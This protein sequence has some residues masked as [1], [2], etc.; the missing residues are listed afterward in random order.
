MRKY[1]YG[2][3]VAYEL[4]SKKYSPKNEPNI[5]FC[6]YLCTELSETFESS[7]SHSPCYP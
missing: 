1:L 3:C 6:C 2:Y 7:V 5:P 4:L